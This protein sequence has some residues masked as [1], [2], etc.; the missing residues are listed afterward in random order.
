MSL[1]NCE[2]N[3]MLTW[4]VDYVISTADGAKKICNN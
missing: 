3:L 2:I 1:I 4:R